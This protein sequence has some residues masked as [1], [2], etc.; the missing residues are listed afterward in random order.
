VVAEPLGKGQERS[1]HCQGPQCPSR[2]V[3]AVAQDQHA[4]AERRCGGSHGSGSSC[5]CTRIAPRQPPRLWAKSGRAR[6]SVAVSVG[7]VA[8][9]R[10]VPTYCSRRRQSRVSGERQTAAFRSNGRGSEPAEGCKLGGR[11]GAS[12]DGARLACSCGGRQGSA[13]ASDGWSRYGIGSRMSG[14]QIDNG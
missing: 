2:V 13:G 4:S 12:F 3:V 6:K 5:G 7:R 11:W 8:R 14:S 1:A 9:P 10:N